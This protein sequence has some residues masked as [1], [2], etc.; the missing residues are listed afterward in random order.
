MLN[1]APAGLCCTLP[2]LSIHLFCRVPYKYHFGGVVTLTKD[3]FVAVNGYSNAYFRWG[4][5]DDD[6]SKRLASHLLVFF[7]GRILFLFCRTFAPATSL[8][9][10]NIKMY[11]DF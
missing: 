10:V 9:L 8:W 5:E 3:Q 4:S 2:I 11:R 7:T 1:G 6:I